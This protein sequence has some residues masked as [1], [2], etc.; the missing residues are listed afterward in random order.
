MPLPLS[1][2]ILLAKINKACAYY[3]KKSIEASTKIKRKKYKLSGNRLLNTFHFFILTSVKEACNRYLRLCIAKSDWEFRKKGYLEK[4]FSYTDLNKCEA[5]DED[6]LLGKI[7]D[8]E[9]GFEYV[10][11]LKGTKFD[12]FK[13]VFIRSKRNP[14]ARLR[15]V[16]LISKALDESVD[17]Y[18]LKLGVQ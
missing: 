14:Y 1:D 17:D 7:R 13:K 18:L 16:D 6:D 8:Q 9:N 10:A 5:L 11:K 15:N 2:N 4:D 3:D 12:K